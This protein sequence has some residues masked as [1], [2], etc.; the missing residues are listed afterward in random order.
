MPYNEVEF[1]DELG[2][3]N[4]RVQTTMNQ[5]IELHLKGTKYPTFLP[6]SDYQI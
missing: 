5:I 3:M 4:P 1:K 2:F 6:N